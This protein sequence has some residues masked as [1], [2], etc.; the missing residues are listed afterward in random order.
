[1]P[2]ALCM[3]AKNFD[4][5]SFNDVGVEQSQTFGSHPSSSANQRTV[6]SYSIQLPAE[7]ELDGKS[8]LLLE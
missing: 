6:H 5:T 4:T 3:L 8:L 2:C 7:S 1:M